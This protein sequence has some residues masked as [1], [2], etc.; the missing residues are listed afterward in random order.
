MMM[1]VEGERSRRRGALAPLKRELE[2][3]ARAL[4]F[5]ALGVARATRLGPEG[6]QLRAWLAAGYHGEMA[7]MKRH[8][9]VRRWPRHPG[10]LPTARSVVML[11]WAYPQ[12]QDIDLGPGRVAKYAGGRDYHRVLG[13]A[14]R[15]LAFT[16]EAA[17][18]RSRAGVDS[19]PIFERA[20][21]VRAGL[22]FV[23]KNCCLIVPGVGSHVFLG[24][25]VTEA[26]LP[27]D[28]PQPSRCGTCRLCLDVC[29]T[30][31]FVGP[32]RLDARRC[33]AYLTIETRK[34]IP[35][36]L[37]E[38]V[39][40][41]LFGCDACQDVCPYNR[42]QRR[43]LDPDT[44]EPFAPRLALTQSSAA[45]WLDQDEAAFDALTLGSPLRRAKREGLAANAAIVLGN[46]GGPE[47]EALL[48]RVAATHPSE[49]VR[50]HA[51]W[52]LPVLR[53]R[54]PQ[55]P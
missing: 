38:G 37:R 9:A 41:W 21:A 55:V 32:G 20:W 10:M 48:A 19:L 5:C 15:K 12:Q 3:E 6:E 25:L 4:G 54:L 2:A 17:G 36:P 42:G 33:I 35:E 51:A 8:A 13:K 28:R 23:G 24:A 11:A 30:R 49:R 26:P 18:Y 53:R 39:G 14:L 44:L 16:L 22:G 1:R 31:A 7:Y 40:D 27:V 52:A 43:S 34:P 45:Q 47:H 29:P 50:E 46:A